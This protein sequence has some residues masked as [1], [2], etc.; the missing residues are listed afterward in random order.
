MMQ[1]IV[2]QKAVAI[3]MRNGD[4]Q[5]K[6]LSSLNDIVDLRKIQI[7]WKMIS[8]MNT[9]FHDSLRHLWEYLVYMGVSVDQCLKEE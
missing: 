3:K 5:Q 6:H 4:D 9:L 7:S 8:D 1:S 2:L